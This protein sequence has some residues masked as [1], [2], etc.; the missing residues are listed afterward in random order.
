[1]AWFVLQ[2]ET[3]PPADGDM[4]ANKRNFSARRS[5]GVLYSRF[6]LPSLAIVLRQYQTYRKEDP[7]SPV[8]L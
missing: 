4:S 2:K 7:I 1:M 3:P 5:F 6:S 8:L